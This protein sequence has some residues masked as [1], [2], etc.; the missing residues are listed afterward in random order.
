MGDESITM[1]A[2]PNTRDKV[3]VREMER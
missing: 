2:R 3:S 1:A